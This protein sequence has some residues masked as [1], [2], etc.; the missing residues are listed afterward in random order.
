MPIALD[1]GTIGHFKTNRT[2]QRLET[3]K[4]SIDRMQTA[5]TQTTSRQRDIQRFGTELRFELRCTQRIAPRLKRAFDRCFALIDFG[6][7][8]ATR[9]GIKL[10]E[11]FEQV[12]DAATLAKEACLRL[13]KGGSIR[14]CDESGL[15]FREYLIEITH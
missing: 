2:K 12:G 11:S 10:A 4:D 3:L 14:R 1:F 8:G 6:T 5:R 7:C 9:L 13:L 15:R